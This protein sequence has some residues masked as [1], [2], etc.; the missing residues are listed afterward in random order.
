MI[1][2]YPS[3]A[4]CAALVLAIVPPAPTTFSTTSCCP[5]VRDMLSPTMRATTSVGPPAAKGT[6]SVIGRSGY[7]AF[8]SS[9]AASMTARTNRL[10]L[11]APPS[12]GGSL[13]DEHLLPAGADAG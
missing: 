6:M 10:F 9:G 4:A 5:S 7:A 8:P 3:G 13:L 11:I 2:V 12:D 1:R